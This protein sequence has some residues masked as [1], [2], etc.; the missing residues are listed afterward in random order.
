M[1]FLSSINK[2]HRLVFA[3]NTVVGPKLAKFIRDYPE[4]VLDITTNDSR[5]HIVAAGFDAGINFGEYI[6]KDM[7]AVRVSKDHRAAIVGAPSYFK[8]HPKPKTPHD[9]LQHR[10]INFRRR[11]E[12]RPGY[13][14][15]TVRLLHPLFPVRGC[16]GG[17]AAH[18]LSRLPDRG[19]FYCPPCEL[20]QQMDI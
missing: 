17:S 8:S 11:A 7:V 9:L 14:F 12:A 16:I 13:A 1:A 20:R 4:L 19:L 3:G 18:M 2:E 5:L 6:Q 10:C 15:R